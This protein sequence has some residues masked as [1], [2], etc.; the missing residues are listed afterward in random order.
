MSE[1]SRVLRFLSVG[2]EI[3]GHAVQ[4][5]M[6]LGLD[7]QV[8]DEL[9]TGLDAVFH[10]EAVAHGVVGDIV[11]DAQVVGAVHRHAAAVGVMDRGI[12]DVLPG[13]FAAQVPVDGVARER[14]VLAHARQLDARDVHLRA[15]HR[16]DVSA[17]VVLVGIL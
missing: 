4:C 17:E 12:A 16:H 1:G 2:G 11:L 14:H 15:R 6:T 8:P 3:H 13:A 5:R 10:E 7:G 9:V